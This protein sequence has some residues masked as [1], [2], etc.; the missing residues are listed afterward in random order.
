MLPF[1]Y[2]K[3]LLLL[4]LFSVTQRQ[5]HLVQNMVARDK[6]ECVAKNSLIENTEVQYCNNPHVKF[7]KIC[8]CKLY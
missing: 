5:H 2:F 7:V 3:I 4:G 1:Y 6:V 8:F